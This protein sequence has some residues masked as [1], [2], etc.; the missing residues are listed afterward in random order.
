[1]WLYLV[2][3][4][5]ID[6]GKL[7]APK[8]PPTVFGV[9]ESKYGLSM[10]W[11]S[12]GGEPAPCSRVLLGGGGPRHNSKFDLKIAGGRAHQGQKSWGISSL[13]IESYMGRFAPAVPLCVCVQAHGLTVQP[14]K[15]GAYACFLHGQGHP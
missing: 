15:G 10:G 2:I 11:F 12:V 1:M 4:G 3:F 9:K 6:Q 7:Y 14:H 8:V 13:H 5:A